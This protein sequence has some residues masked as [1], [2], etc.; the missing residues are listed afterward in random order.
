MRYAEA[1]TVGRSA[2]S[3]RDTYTYFKVLTVQPESLDG[4]EQQERLAATEDVVDVLIR[5][6]VYACLRTTIADP[7]IDR[8]SR[9]AYRSLHPRDAALQ[10]LAKPGQ[11]FAARSF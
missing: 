1:S 6:V 2:L 11:L 3:F 9:T 7:Q 8:F 5:V 4:S 10:V